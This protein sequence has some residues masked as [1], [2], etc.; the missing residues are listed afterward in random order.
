MWPIYCCMKARKTPD[1]DLFTW[2]EAMQS[3]YKDQMLIAS[4]AEIDELTSKGTWE[5]GLR[6]NA[7]TKIIP[8]KWVFR[9]KRNSEGTHI[10]K[11]KGRIVLR[12]DLQ[13]DISDEDMFSPVAAWP[14]V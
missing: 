1:P 2:Q 10:T 9:N 14:N 12:G 6:S 4:Q 3:D 11:H 5:E 8:C 13:T 7:T